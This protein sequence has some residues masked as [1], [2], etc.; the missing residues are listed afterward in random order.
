MRHLFQATH[1]PLI[2]HT[3]MN[4]KARNSPHP[5][6]ANPTHAD[7]VAVFC[8]LYPVHVPTQKDLVVPLDQASG[9]FYRMTVFDLHTDTI[10]QE[11]KFTKEGSV[12]GVDAVRS[13]APAA[14]ALFRK[15]VAK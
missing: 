6:A 7:L 2:L 1:L 8:A 4:H 13:T 15:A 5:P 14:S 12:M 3:E 10:I 9:F 11:V